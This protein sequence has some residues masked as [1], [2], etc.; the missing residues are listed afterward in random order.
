[1]PNRR[2]LV[3]WI[4]PKGD[5]YTAA[6][7]SEKTRW[8]REPATRVFGAAHDARS[9]VEQEAAAL[10]GVPVVWEDPTGPIRS[11]EFE[12]PGSERKLDEGSLAEAA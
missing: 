9:W 4:E 1:M 8:L 11:L 6:F 7:V 2:T 3:A 5:H 12:L 10:G